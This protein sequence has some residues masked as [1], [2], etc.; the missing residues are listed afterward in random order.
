MRLRPCG[1]KKSN[2]RERGPTKGN[3]VQTVWIGKI[4]PQIGWTK[5]KSDSDHVDQKQVQFQWG[6]NR[7]ILSKFFVDRKFKVNCDTFDFE[8]K[9]T[10]SKKET[11]SR[12]DRHM[13]KS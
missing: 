1:P 8:K 7:Q 9:N 6:F 11:N 12:V 2:L 3:P 4:Y 10:K 5:K 13:Q